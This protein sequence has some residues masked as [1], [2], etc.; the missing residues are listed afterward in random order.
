MA[1]VTT[2]TLCF[3]T[4]R[5]PIT[6]PVVAHLVK[7]LLWFGSTETESLPIFH[8]RLHLNNPIALSNNTSN[9]CSVLWLFLYKEYTPD[10]GYLAL[11]LKWFYVVYKN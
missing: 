9:L 2:I 10:V 6:H 5:R 4:F 8:C 7:A 1:V 3:R 11:S